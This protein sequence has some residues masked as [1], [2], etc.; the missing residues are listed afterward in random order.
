[1][2]SNDNMLLKTSSIYI[3][4]SMGNVLSDAGTNI[5]QFNEN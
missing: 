2:L 5:S 4:D 3:E 1:M